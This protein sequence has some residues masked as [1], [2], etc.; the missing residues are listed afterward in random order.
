MFFADF[1]NFPNFE[2][3]FPL[4]A[5]FRKVET[6]P[7]KSRDIQLPKNT[8]Q[9]PACP[10]TSMKIIL[11]NQVFTMKTLLKIEQGFESQIFQLNFYS[12]KSFKMLET[13]RGINIHPKVSVGVKKST[14]QKN[15][16]EPLQATV[17]GAISFF[18]CP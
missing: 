13:P 9:L 10:G 2:G 16:G 4:S 14:K 7:V 3:L 18:L 8:I 12:L 6:F 5:N 11:E 1:Q 15:I 17:L